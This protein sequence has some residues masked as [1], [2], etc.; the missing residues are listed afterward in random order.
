MA[1]GYWVAFGDVTDPEGYKA[2]IAANAVAFRKYGARFLIRGGAS[3]TPEGHTR[4]RCVVIEFPS[5][6]DALACTRSENYAQALA[7]RQG[8]SVVDLTIVEG[9]DGLQPGDA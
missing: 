6:A 1:E 8:R 5:Y 4:S 7:L 3:E 2:Y 9:Y